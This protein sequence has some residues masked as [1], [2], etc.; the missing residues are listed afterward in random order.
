MLATA[1]LIVL[2]I[3]AFQALAESGKQI[4]SVI[5]RV[6]VSANRILVRETHGR[7]EMPLSVA[8][9]V[10]VETPSGPGSLAAVHAGDSVTVR[11]G[12]GPNGETAREIRVTRPA[13]PVE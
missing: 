2:A 10:K 1:G 3:A 6:D 11:H 12:P 13:A 5:E 4:K 7:H 8:P 9:D